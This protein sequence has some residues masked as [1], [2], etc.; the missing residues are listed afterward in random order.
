MGLKRGFPFLKYPTLLFSL[1]RICHF[2]REG[3]AGK[4]G[5]TSED[6]LQYC[7][8]WDCQPQALSPLI[9]ALDLWNIKEIMVFDLLSEISDSGSTLF[10]D[11]NKMILRNTDGTVKQ[12]VLIFDARTSSE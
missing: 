9:G 10:V 3:N 1:L 6:C 7:N 5:A 11:V 4:G 2:G 8:L 12:R